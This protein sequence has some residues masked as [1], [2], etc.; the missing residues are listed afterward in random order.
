M[1][2][3]EKY[4]ITGM[5]CVAC[6]A[7]VD[8]AVRNLK[9]IKKVNVNLLTNSMVVS[10]DD[11]VLS[12]EKIITTVIKSGYGASLIKESNS[13]SLKEELKDEQTPKLLWRLIFSIILLIPLFYLC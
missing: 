12:S 11:N 8:K 2:I 10:Y 1:I 3:D 6:S 9:G 5:S 4:K 13:S 7:R